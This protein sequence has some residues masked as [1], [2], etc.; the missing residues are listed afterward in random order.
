MWSLEIAQLC[1]SFNNEQ[2]WSES[3]K[4]KLPEMAQEKETGLKTEAALFCWMT[5]NSE[6]IKSLQYTDVEE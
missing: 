6:M 1:S 3:G 2:A 4:G 5:S